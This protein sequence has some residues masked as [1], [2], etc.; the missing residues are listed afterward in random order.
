MAQ[1]DPY[2]EFRDDPDEVVE[3]N[4]LVKTLT[5]L[6]QE[7]VA[8]EALVASLEQQLADA[9]EKLREI[10]EGRLPAVMDEIDLGSYSTKGGIEIEIK[11][12]IRGSIPKATESEAF[13]WLE[14]NDNANLIKRQFVIEF[15][16]DEEKWANKFEADL[17][18]RKRQLAV[19]RKKAVNPQ[20]L[21]AFVR[22]KLS[23]GVD[24]PMKLFGVYRQRFAKV[25]VKEQD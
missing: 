16:K 21:Q 12:A 24:F 7:Q 8:A 25:T 5:D 11:E 15:G 10:R 2:A 20:T 18:K 4:N 17:K 23:E 9:K 13:Q 19:A 1:S 14:D 6:A 3:S 22:T